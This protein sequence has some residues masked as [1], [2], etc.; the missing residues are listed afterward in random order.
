VNPPKDFFGRD[1]A[2][3]RILSMKAIW[4]AQAASLYLIGCQPMATRSVVPKMNLSDPYFFP[5]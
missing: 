5:L 1:K 4:G 3:N 2:N